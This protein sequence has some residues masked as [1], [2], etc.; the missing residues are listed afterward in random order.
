MFGYGVV[1]QGHSAEGLMQVGKYI[2]YTCTSSG[3]HIHDHAG[4]KT[5][6]SRVP[7]VAHISPM[8]IYTAR[9]SLTPRGPDNSQWYGKKVVQEGEN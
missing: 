9:N 3:S 5:L 8:I 7:R 6:Y 2:I 4:P 1:L